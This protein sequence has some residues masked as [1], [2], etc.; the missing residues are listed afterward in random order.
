[1]LRRP[2]LLEAQLLHA[3]LPDI[4]AARP[5]IVPLDKLR[6][7]FQ[8]GGDKLL[9]CQPDV[10]DRDVPVDRLLRRHVD[11]YWRFY[12]WSPP[13]DELTGKVPIL[14]IQIL[15]RQ[16]DPRLRVV[17]SLACWKDAHA[18]VA[19]AKVGLQPRES[20]SQR[21]HIIQ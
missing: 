12:R 11:V 7:L 20:I 4:V 14:N 2:A 15:G 13:E 9:R 19:A 3:A 17:L 5:A 6:L 16:D 21:I 1:S 8:D 10:L 18:Q